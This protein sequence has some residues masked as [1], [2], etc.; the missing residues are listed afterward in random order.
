MA[1]LKNGSRGEQVAALQRQLKSLGYTLKD[2]GVFGD[3]TERY[4]KEVQRRFK[5]TDDG[6]VG[7]KTWAVLNTPNSTLKTLTEADYAWA[8]DFLADDVASVKAVREVEAPQGG[9]LPDGRV[10]ILYERH[11]MYRQLFANG[12]DP[13]KY[14]ASNPDIVNKKTG[15]YLGKAAEYKRLAAAELIDQKSALESCSWGA[16]QIMGYHWKILGFDSVYSFVAKM[17]E[18]ERGQ[19]ECFVRFIKSQPALLKAIRSDDWVTFARYYNGSNY[20]AN[21][22]DDKLQ[23]AFIKYGGLK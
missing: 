9:F 5:L 20:R 7:D 19:L 23:A 11:V 6:V 22:Y 18:S 8:A 17:K 14:A 15:G 10:T 12:F 3:T 16:Y 1:L 2:D 4:V 13:D 21:K